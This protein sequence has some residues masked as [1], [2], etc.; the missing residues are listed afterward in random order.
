MAMRGSVERGRYLQQGPSPAHHG[1]FLDRPRYSP[2]NGDEN[3]IAD[4]SPR[5]RKWVEDVHPLL[6]FFN[7]SQRDVYALVKSAEYDLDRVQQAV[8]AIVEEKKGHEQGSWEVVRTKQQKQMQKAGGSGS[9]GGNASAHK[10]RGGGGGS[11]FSSTAFNGQA[12]RFIN[13]TATARGGRRGGGGGASSRGGMAGRQQTHAPDGA[14]VDQQR[15]GREDGGGRGGYGY[16]GQKSDGRP[17]AGRPTGA[18]TRKSHV[19]FFN[20]HAAASISD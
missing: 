9:G 7:F 3:N 2:L 18:P 12:G 8:A 11:G 19:S 16:Q 17:S 6:E 20:V 13:G 4:L 1:V 14:A 15:A 5:G 10:G